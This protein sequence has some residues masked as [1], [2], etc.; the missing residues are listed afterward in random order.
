MELNGG[1]INQSIIN[2]HGVKFVFRDSMRIF[3]GSLDDLCKDLKPYFRKQT[4][5]KF[6]FDDLNSDNVYNDA[7]L[8]AEISDYLKHD[9]LS[10]AQILIEFRDKLLKEP[11]I[12]LDICDCFTS[13]TLAKKLYFNKYYERYT[14]ATWVG[15]KQTKRRYIW[16]VNRK[17]D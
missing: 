16:Q 1:V 13:A 8:K 2:K 7:S 15:G 4:G 3:A 9:C 10:L 14:K 11:T 5:H 17:T 12:E 6:K